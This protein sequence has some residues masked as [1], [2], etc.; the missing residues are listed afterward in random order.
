M[1]NLCN[2]GCGKPLIINGKHVVKP[3]ISNPNLGES[4]KLNGRWYLRK[5]AKSVVIEMWEEANWLVEQMAKLDLKMLKTSGR[6]RTIK[7][8]LQKQGFYK[9]A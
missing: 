6:L 1:I 4:V 3:T 8:D 7:T 9:S 5:C 2:C